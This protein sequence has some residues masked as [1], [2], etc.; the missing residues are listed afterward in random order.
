MIKINK[1]ILYA[2]GGAGLLIAFYLYLRKGKNPSVRLE[3]DGDKTKIIYPKGFEVKNGYIELL[4]IETNTPDPTIDRIIVTITGYREE[5]PKNEKDSG[6]RMFKY[7]DIDFTPAQD[8]KI[9]DEKTKLRLRAQSGDK[10][11]IKTDFKLKRQV[12]YN[13][14]LN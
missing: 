2:I 1:N 3:K 8:T 14:F 10:V 11:K 5:K 7:E 4:A 12:D 6:L 9:S 13:T